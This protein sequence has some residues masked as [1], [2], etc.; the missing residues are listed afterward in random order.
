MSEETIPF[1]GI[2][3]PLAIS[4]GYD[5]ITV[6]NHDI[7]TGH[8]VYDRISASLSAYGIPLLGGNVIRVGSGGSYFP[9][10]SVFRKAGL[11][12]LV[13]G[14]E[15]ANMKS[16]LSESLWSGMDFLSLVPFVQECVD[17]AKTLM[18]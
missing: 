3:V 9:V 12:V 1:V 5:A 2:A 7:E 8:D 16:W 6:G 10:Y 13:L 18:D 4:M 15:N 14:F 17:R 11:K